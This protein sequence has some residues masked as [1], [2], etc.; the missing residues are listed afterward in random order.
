MVVSAVMP[1]LNGQHGHRHKGITLVELM[2]AMVLGLLVAAGI[3]TVLIST[4]NSNKAQMQ[5]ARLQE[6]GRFAHGQ[7]SILHKFRRRRAGD[8]GRDVHG[9]CARA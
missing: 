3:I 5:L 6:E 9:S 1:R 8:R 7:W 2:I 4:S